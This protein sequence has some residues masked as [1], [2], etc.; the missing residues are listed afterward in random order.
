MPT[1][2]KIF[3]LSEQRGVLIVVPKGDAVGFRDTDVDHELQ[4]ILSRIEAGGS[5]SV[6][7]DLGGSSYFGSVMIGAVNAIGKTARD[8]GGE[9][10]ICN[11]SPEMK[12]VM[13]AMKLDDLWEQYESRS[14]AVKAVKKKSR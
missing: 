2:W 9:M 3:G 12:A 4:E 13:N 6:V 10:A 8:R 11:A 7:V 5:S 1:T 14:A